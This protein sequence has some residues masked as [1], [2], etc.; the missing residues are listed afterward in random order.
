MRKSYGP[1]KSVNDLLAV[2]RI[3][4]KKLEKMRKYPVAGKSAPQKTDYLHRQVPVVHRFN[5]EKASARN[6]HENFHGQGI[7]SP[8][9]A[10]GQGKT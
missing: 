2:R 5:R 1:F 10:R 8:G 6:A 7:A 9:C 4:P 3:G